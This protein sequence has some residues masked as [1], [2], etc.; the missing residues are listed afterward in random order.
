M[1][2]LAFPSPCTPPLPLTSALMK[3]LIMA[4]AFSSSHHPTQELNV[5]GCK[6]V[7]ESLRHFLQVELL[8]G[9]NRFFCS[10]CSALQD[11]SRRVLLHALPPHLIVQ[12]KRFVFDEKARAETPPII[13]G[14]A[15]SFA[16]FGG[17]CAF[18]LS[19]C[20]SR[21]DM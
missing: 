8:T 16:F 5:K 18:S 4:P 10:R 12:L 13:R 11:A 7:E 14:F 19:A 20:C 2:H 21:E 9:S 1:P 15:R 17:R 3:P 6:T